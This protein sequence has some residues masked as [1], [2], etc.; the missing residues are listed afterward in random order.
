MKKPTFNRR[1][2]EFRFSKLCKRWIRRFHGECSDN[3][4]LKQPTKCSQEHRDLSTAQQFQILPKN[5]AATPEMPNHHIFPNELAGGAWRHF[6]W[7][8]I[9][10]GFIAI[11]GSRFKEMLGKTARKHEV[12]HKSWKN[13]TTVEIA[14]HQTIPNEM[15]F[16]VWRHLSGNFVFHRTREGRLEI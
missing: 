16:W 5:N 11:L 9:S 2:D 10:Y 13:A 7:N 1:T 8:F 12:E 4:C 15:A 14:N 3:S 6:S